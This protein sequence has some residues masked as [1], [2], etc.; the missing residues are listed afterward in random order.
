VVREEKSGERGDVW[1]Y[2]CPRRVPASK[3]CCLCIHTDIRYV[4]RGTWICVTHR[5]AVSIQTHIYMYLDILYLFRRTSICIWTFGMYS[6]ARLYAHIGVYSDA[7]LYAQ[8]SG[9]RHSLSEWLTPIR[10]IVD[11]FRFWYTILDKRRHHVSVTVCLTFWHTMLDMIL[12]H[13]FRI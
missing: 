4:L 13:Y 10:D 12:V 7:H 1:T 3:L 2:S 11:G 5:H 8:T 6:D 9:S